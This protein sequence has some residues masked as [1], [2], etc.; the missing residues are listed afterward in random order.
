[1]AVTGDLTRY[2]YISTI[3][4]GG[5]ATVDLAED[6]RLGR[7]VALKRFTGAADDGASRLRREALA[8]ASI[9]HPNLVSVF[10][11][12]TS[13]E[14]D[15]VVVMEYVRGETL[16]DALNRRGVLPTGETLRILDGVAAGL[17]AIHRRGIVHRDIK[18]SNILLGDDGAVKVA[19][20]GIASVPD[21][22]QITT[23]GSVLG[24]LRYMA[25]EQ[26]E[27]QPAS[28]ASDIYALAAVAYEMLTGAKARQETN[29][30]ALAHAIATQPAPDLRDGWAQAPAAA[31]AVIRDAMAADPGRRP[32][33]AGAFAEA[34]RDAFEGRRGAP[35]GAVA[36]GGAAAAAAA[37]GPAT[38]AT[39]ASP[40][41]ARELPRRTPEP[42]R[43][44]SGGRDRVGAWLLAVLVAIGVAV[45]LAV[46][47]SGG[48]TSAGH[49]A[50]AGRSTHAH[51]PTHSASSSASTPAASTPS[52][53][54]TP[55][56]ASQSQT[57]ASTPTQSSSSTTAQSSTQSGPVTPAPN[58]SN[59][60]SAVTTFYGL[61]AGHQFRTAWALADPA[62]R[63]Q[64]Q[65]YHQF[66]SSQQ[67]DRSIDFS[68]AKVVKQ[69]GNTAIVAVK[70]TS[71]R[72]DGTTQC[73]GAVA[74]VQ[75]PAGWR[76][77]QIQINCH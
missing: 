18:P 20:L 2:R 60:I 24:S 57:S 33:S 30:G 1:M 27:D 23:T 62:F 63:A 75:T 29:P 34:L 74:V 68:E 38:A 4:T 61:A 41:A 53:P 3:G 70:T 48:S 16:R 22:T 8:G 31:A 17:D 32:R 39:V 40:A 67:A 46:L 10:D 14:G 37:A 19:D 12:V 26:L 47:L 35:G 72:T 71:H 6:S 5:M 54:S 59:P 15:L 9:S 45:I 66:V 11:A 50:S 43:R 13:D 76:L 49:R 21:H 51:A 65:G 42:P 55:S 28:P 58:A 52:T 73:A 69:S 7:E 44:R 56:S 25:P 36:A 77:H 64:L